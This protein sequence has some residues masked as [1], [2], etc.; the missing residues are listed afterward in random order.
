MIIRTLIAI[1]LVSS[2]G[3]AQEDSVKQILA[4][5]L[6]FSLANAGNIDSALTLANELLSQDPDLASILRI[7]GQIHLDR[8]DPSSAVTPLRKYW[9]V[10]PN[11]W[12]VLPELIN[13]YQLVG[14]TV[15]RDSIRE[16]LLSL[17]ASSNDTSLTSQTE[18]VLDVFRVDTSSIEVY[19]Q[20]NPTGDRPVFLLFYWFNSTGQQIG[21]FALRSNKLDTDIALELG[22]LKPGERRYTLDYYSGNYH[23]TYGFFNGQPGYEWTKNLVTSAID[24]SLKPMSHSTFER[25]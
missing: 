7:V 13:A 14:D 9:A 6:V 11:D 18:Y 22:T 3:R 15:H 16:E 4:V 24:G 25:K 21:Y 23:A 17:H 5:D 12:T 19:E 8:R 1:L 10:R 20:L 2:V